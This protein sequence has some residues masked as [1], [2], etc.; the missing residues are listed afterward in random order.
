MP[1]AVCD[2]SP[3]LLPDRRRLRGEVLW[4]AVILAL[5]ALGLGLSV[6]WNT[7]RLHW[8]ARGLRGGD[9]AS[10][11]R[12]KEAGIEAIPALLWVIENSGP[13]GELHITVGQDGGVNLSELPEPGETPSLRAAKLLAEL[14]EVGESALLERFGTRRDPLMRARLAVGLRAF[15]SKRAGTAYWLALFDQDL[16]IAGLSPCTGPAEAWMEHLASLQEEDGRWNARKWGAEGASD[17]E[18]TSLCA[19]GFM[20]YGHSSLY[21]K[22]RDNLR[23][24]LT[25]VAGH[26]R[27]I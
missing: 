11:A 14:G 27:H 7:I 2:A 3:A 25:F 13:P 1:D 19:L 5:G 12:L 20:A 16:V 17:L 24:A 18:V 4:L 26:Q 10:E 21:G 23:R 9:A 8:W 22:H 15:K 6:S